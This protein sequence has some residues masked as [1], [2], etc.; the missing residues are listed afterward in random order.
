M[1]F[2]YLQIWQVWF[3]VDKLSSAHVYLRLKPGETLT[4]VK[5]SVVEE[6][7]QLVKA[8]SI[9]GCKLKDTDVVYTMWANLQKTTDMEV[10]Q[11]GFHDR[12]KVQKMKVVKNNAI[13]NRINK[14][15]SVDSKLF[16]KPQLLYFMRLLTPTF[17]FL[18]RSHI[19]ISL[20]F[21]KRGLLR[22]TCYI[23]QIRRFL[24]YIH[25]F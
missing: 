6:C 21:N 4:D 11:I 23:I 18:Q 20:I 17:F 9:E 24:S 3:H 8:N 16:T 1:T 19:P 25:I 22:S 12:A 13:V 2:L 15:Q 14:T 10:G 5:P 7:A